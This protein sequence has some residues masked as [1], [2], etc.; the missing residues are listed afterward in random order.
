[1]RKKKLRFPPYATIIGQG[2]E[3]IGEVRF[4]G[5]LHVDGKVV[6][7]VT[8]GAEQ[9][10]AITLGAAGVI[11]G[12]L[13]VPYAVLGGT[14]IGDVRASRRAELTSGARIEGTLYYGLLEM[15][16]GAEVNGKL[17]HVDDMA[18]L[19]LG[20]EG[21]QPGEEQHGAGEAPSEEVPTRASEGRTDEADT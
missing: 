11:E 3:V 5:G 9:E 4:D 21:M 2:T 7:N 1:M 20:F 17:V 13:D 6:G 8:G 12:N 14:V 16:E 10:C 19:R 18:P 15:D